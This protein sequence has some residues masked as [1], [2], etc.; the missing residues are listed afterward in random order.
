[1]PLVATTTATFSNSIVADM[2]VTSATTNFTL[3]GPL[4]TTV[5]FVAN[6]NI[7][8]SAWTDSTIC[9]TGSTHI[10]TEWN[11]TTY[12][13]ASTLD[14]VWNEWN[15]NYPYV[16]VAQARE[17]HRLQAAANA[18]AI[19]Q[20]AP[21]VPRKKTEA[22][23]QAELKRAEDFRKAEVLRQ[24]KEAAAKQRAEKLLFETLTPQQ[25][26]D[27]TKKGSFYLHTQSGR[28]YRIDRHTHGNVYLYDEK[29]R[30]VRKFCAQPSGVPADD[31]ILAQ[32]LA[33]ET[34]ED[35]FLRVANATQ[36]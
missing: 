3:N 23:V 26:E 2:L 12:T 18:C 16:A 13:T 17:A 7:T 5:N 15:T 36:L 1:M 11:N 27:L 20:G 6:N 31:A 32:K 28:K 4:T 8:W 29:D 34:D 9:T 25:K 21:Y 10:W 30:I 33:L 22:E 24:A 19:I 35:S 14:I